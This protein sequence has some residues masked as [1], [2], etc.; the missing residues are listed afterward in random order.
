[1]RIEI[2]KNVKHNVTELLTSNFSTTTKIE[3][4]L[5]CV[6]I[7][8]T[9]QKYFEYE[10]YLTKCGIHNVHFMGTLDD[11]KVL[12]QKT[13]ELK[14]FAVASRDNFGSYIDGLLPIIDQFIQTYQGKVDS[15][16]WNKVMDIEHV[17]GG[18]SGR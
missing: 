1:M 10:C 4:F 13:E 12:R 15:D 8:D 17:G 7:M 3:S 18:R 11:W 9:F 16:F 14:K 2:G 5:S 6:A